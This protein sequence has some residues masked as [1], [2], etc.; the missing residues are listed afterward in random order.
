MAEGLARAKFGAARTRAERGLQPSRVNPLAIEALREA[1]VDISSHVSKSVDTI[2]PATRGPRHHVVRRRGL[3]AG[4]GRRA[5]RPL[6][7]AGSRGPGPEHRAL[8]RS[9]RRDCPASRCPRGRTWAHGIIVGRRDTV[10]EEKPRLRF[11]PS[12][13]GYLHV[14]GARTALFNWLYARRHGARSCCASKIPTWSDH[15]P[16]WSPGSSTGCGGS[17][18]TGMRV[19]RPAEATARTSSRNASIGT[20][21]SRSDSSFRATHTTVIAHLNDCRNI[22]SGQKPQAADGSTI[23]AACRSQLSR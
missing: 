5:A 11:A 21:H 4:S 17:V 16:T 12:P 20:A 8:Q 2:D 14:G 9:A 19:L 15:R 22:A 18:S 23:A 6:A 7:A 3:P 1:G 10:T 13:T